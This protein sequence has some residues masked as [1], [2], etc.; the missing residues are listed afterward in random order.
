MYIYIYITKAMISLYMATTGGLDWTNLWDVLIV[1]GF[2]NSG[3]H[4][5][6]QKLQK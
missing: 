4:V 6:H 3:Q 2:W 5:T 1:T